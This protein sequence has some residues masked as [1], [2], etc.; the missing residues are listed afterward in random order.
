MG[1]KVTKLWACP[2]NNRVPGLRT[3]V[4]VYMRLQPPIQLQRR[5]ASFVLAVYSRFV[6]IC[7]GYSLSQF[8]HRAFQ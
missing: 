8:V 6:T 4:H 7:A 3:V 2:S 5:Y 1:E